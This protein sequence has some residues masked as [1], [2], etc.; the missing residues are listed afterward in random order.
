MSLDPRTNA[1]AEAL[2]NSDA[3]SQPALEPDF[4]Y[5]RIYFDPYFFNVTVVHIPQVDTGADGN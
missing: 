1:Q 4:P 5:E 2:A 3:N